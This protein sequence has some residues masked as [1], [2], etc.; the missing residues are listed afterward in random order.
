MTNSLSKDSHITHQ[1]CY[2]QIPYSGG[3]AEKRASQ[4]KRKEYSSATVNNIGISVNK[5][6]EINFR[7]LSAAEKPV[8]K[9]YTSKT[10]KKLLELAVDNQV[11]Y[12]SAFAL[13][14]TCIFRPVSI[15]ALPSDKKN[16][17]DKKY[18]AAQS[19][20]SGIIGFIISSIVATPVAKAVKKIKANPQNYLKDIK[21]FKND[22]AKMSASTYLTKIPDIAMAA[23]KGVI[24]VALI[25]VILKY[26]FGWE[27][28]NKIKAPKPAQNISGGVK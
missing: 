1:L 2:S 12:S 22:N 23:P 8:S 16:V 11:V 18:A 6:A 14:L 17:D 10:V 13:I 25:P 5:P 21:W 15:M 3:Y 24:T 4:N 19:I 28:K 26:I 9:I 27:K 20:A 7:G